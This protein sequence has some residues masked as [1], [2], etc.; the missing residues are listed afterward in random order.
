MNGFGTIAEQTKPSG[1][2]QTRR[3]TSFESED[4]PLAA[5]MQSGVKPPSPLF[6]GP[7][8]EATSGNEP[9][10]SMS[11]RTHDTITDSDICRARQ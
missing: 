7:A 8:P 1:T 6:P 11:S 9:R 2:S 10:F 3:S 5:A 4:I